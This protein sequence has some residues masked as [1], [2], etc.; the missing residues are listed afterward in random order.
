MAGAPCSSLP[1]G[2]FNASQLVTCRQ[3]LAPL[4]RRGLDAQQARREGLPSSIEG[5]LSGIVIPSACGGGVGFPG[6][7][8]SE[9]GIVFDHGPGN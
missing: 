2:I 1:S 5:L 4:R 8:L 7:H 6:E 9:V 3:R